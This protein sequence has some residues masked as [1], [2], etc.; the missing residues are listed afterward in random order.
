MTDEQFKQ[1]MDLMGELL[2]SVQSIEDMLFD[3][4]I[5]DFQKKVDWNLWEIHN[6]AKFA[7]KGRNAT[8]DNLPENR[9]SRD[10]ER[11]TQSSEEQSSEA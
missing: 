6:L 5:K 1:H 2:E 8:L 7:V 3:A 11:G 10:A 9:P 4:D